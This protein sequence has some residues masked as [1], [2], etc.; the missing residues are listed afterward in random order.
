MTFPVVAPVIIPF[1]IIFSPIIIPIAIFH[2]SYKLCKKYYYGDQYEKYEKHENEHKEIR[3]L[4]L[5][6]NI[7]IINNISEI[8]K[9]ILH[10]NIIIISDDYKKAS[11]YLHGG[12]RVYDYIFYSNLVDNDIITK[13][14]YKYSF[15]GF[16]RCILLYSE[17]LINKKLINKKLHVNDITINTLREYLVKYHKELS[18]CPFCIG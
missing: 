8:M 10:Q 16:P 3:I 14:Y 2:E 7:D 5:H 17:K 15:N 12:S 6:E 9:T 4:I 13:Y 11:Y 1:V 18:K